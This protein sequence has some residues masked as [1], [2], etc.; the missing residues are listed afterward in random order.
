MTLSG[1]SRDVRVGRDERHGGRRARRCGRETA[2]PRPAPGAARGPRRRRTPSAAGSSSCGRAVP[3]RGCASRSPGS[4]GR[5]SNSADGALRADGVR[6]V[7]RGSVRRG[8]LGH[9]A[10]DRAGAAGPCDRKPPGSSSSVCQPLGVRESLGRDGLRER[11]G[12]V[13][14]HRPTE[15][16]ARGTGRSPPGTPGT[17]TARSGGRP[18]PRCVSVTAP[19]RAARR[20]SASRARSVTRHDAVLGAVDE[21]HRR[22]DRAGRPRSRSPIRPCGRGAAGRRGS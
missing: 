5:P 10:A 6:D 16:R 20:A 9:A 18:R 19:G 4:R 13:G 2:R 7:H 11:R 1:G 14:R 3:R 8:R 12:V 21:Q 17:R 22:L 15:R